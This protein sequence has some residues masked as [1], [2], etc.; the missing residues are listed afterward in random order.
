M[1][2]QNDKS[3]DEK[4]SLNILGVYSF[5]ADKATYARFIRELIDSHDPPN[6][7]EEVKG[8]LR[9]GGRGD[10]MVPLTPEER[11]DLESELRFYMDDAAVLEVLVKNPDPQFNPHDFA[12]IDPANP[13]DHSEMTWNEM[14]LAADG[15]T[16]IRT[17]YR[18]RLPAAKQYRVVFVIH[19]WMPS[20]PL[21]SSY[22]E[23]QAPPVQ[24]LPER[25]WRLAPY[26]LPEPSVGAF[27]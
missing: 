24:P 3:A 5:S 25:L 22:G 27:Q 17:D 7:S 15:E 13:K 2:D 23:L 6:F 21:L 9:L 12:Q 16:E 11:Q 19:R 20:L 4:P 8:I 26:E 18:Q 1:L 10:E 14:F